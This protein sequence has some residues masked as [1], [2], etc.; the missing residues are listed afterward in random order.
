MTFWKQPRTWVVLLTVGL[1]VFLLYQFW[2]WEVERV[3]VEPDTFLVR[4][5]LWGKDLPKGEIVAPDDDYK[6]IQKKVLPEGR[7]FLNPLVYRYESYPILDVPAGQC[8]VLTCKAGEEMPAERRAKGEFLVERNKEGEVTERGIVREVLLPGKHRLNP[9]VFEHKLVKMTNVSGS[10]VGVKTLL[11]GKDPSELKDRKSKYVVPAGYRGVQEKSVPPGDYYLNPH[12]ETVVPVD[13][14]LHQVEF[15]DIYFPSKDGFT[16]QPHVRVSYKVLPSRAPEL[17]VMLCDQGILPQLDRTAEDVKKNPILQKFVLP[18]IRG[19]V[20]IE[21]SK[22][23]ARDYVSQQKAQKDSVN[24]RE[25]LRK[26]LEEKVKP[27]CEEVGVM[28]ESITVAQLEMNPDLEKLAAQ[29]FIRETTEAIRAKNAKLVEQYESEKEQKSRESLRERQ[30]KM[31]VAKQNL[32][33]AETL[34]KQQLEVEEARLKT[35]FRAATTRLEAAKEQAKATVTR[36]KAEASI[37][38]AQ[39]EAEVAGLRTAVG[40]FPTPDHFAQYHVLTKLSPALS[41]I[42]ASDDSEFG[43]MFAAYMSGRMDAFNNKKQ[44]KK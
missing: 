14:D 26:V 34:A 17:Y 23:D 2:V 20:R 30:S 42:F 39:N 4:I 40:G 37:I 33:V 27:Q 8:A 10:Q 6:G 35:D 1:G 29:I 31:V 5:D 7:H 25:Q 21:G 16:I 36:G 11:W 44:A 43:K 32:E 13:V 22:Y 9:Y 19:W 12:V 24:P 28:I 3:E 41:E 18:L 15:S 38:E